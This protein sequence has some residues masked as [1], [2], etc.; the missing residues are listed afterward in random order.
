MKILQVIDSLG[1]GG[2]EKLIVDIVPKMSNENL[3]IDVLL[4]N[5]E[6]TS[7]YDKLEAENCCNIFSLGKS[8]YNPL[9]ILRIIPY[10][11]KYDL[12]HV[13]LFPVLYYVA[14]AKFISRSKVPLIFTE[15]STGNKRMNNS[16]LRNIERWIYSKYEKIICITPQVKEMLTSSLGIDEKKLEIIENGID[17]DTIIRQDAYDKSFLNYTK[18]DKLM[19]MVAGFR[20]QKDQETV[21]Q[22]LK[23][24]PSKYKLILV[25]DGIRRPVLEKLVKKL[26]FENRVDFLGIRSDVYSL[27]KM[28]DVAILS[29]HW[30]GFGLAAAEAMACKIPTLAS[31]VVGLAEVVD[32]GGILFEKGNSQELAEKI[33]DLEDEH[34]HK[35]IMQRGYNKSKQY[36]IEKMIEKLLNAYNPEH[37]NYNRNC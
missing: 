12:I 3:K 26:D 4:L 34:Y 2:A 1:V 37:T 5:G 36:S 31:N 17:L 6:K 21:I 22:A 15:H 33:L 19:I 13:H 27:Y 20:E 29:S 25:G 9:H 23:F 35:E 10:L 32:N 30:E 8:Y 7:F 18:E 28:C 24:L 14:I 16:K 11:S